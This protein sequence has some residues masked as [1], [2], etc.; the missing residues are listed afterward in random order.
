MSHGKPALKSREEIREAQQRQQKQLDDLAR[1]DAWTE[2]PA[3]AQAESV[4]QPVPGGAGQGAM[5]EAEITTLPARSRGRPAKHVV[6]V[7]DPSAPWRVQMEVVPMHQC[8]IRLPREVYQKLK[9]L[10]ETTYGESMND[11]AMAAIE[12]EV[13]RRLKELE[14][15]RARAGEG[16]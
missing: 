5:D 2:A 3:R 8:S 7:T 9:Y 10:G 1:L 4:N 15:P 13:N 11:I 12:R 14:Q 16:A 6:A